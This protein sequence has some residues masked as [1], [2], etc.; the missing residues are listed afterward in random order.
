MNDTTDCILHGLCYFFEHRFALQ[1]C[2]K[3]LPHWNFGLVL[4]GFFVPSKIEI[5]AGFQVPSLLQVF[6]DKFFKKTPTRIF[7]SNLRICL[8]P[9]KLSNK[10][11]FNTKFGRTSPFTTGTAVE[12]KTESGI[13]DLVF[14][15]FVPSLL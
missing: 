14:C 3:K 2:T 1:D 4:G 12:K 11:F 10:N 8:F 6:S 13:Q 9:G 15:F 5:M 7:R